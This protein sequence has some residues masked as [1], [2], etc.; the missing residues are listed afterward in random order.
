MCIK[1]SLNDVFPIR[2]LQASD[3]PR[4][5]FQHDSPGWGGLVWD[6]NPSKH[7]GQ[8]SLFAILIA[9]N[10]I[11][12]EG[13]PLFFLASEI[14]LG[15]RDSFLLALSLLFLGDLFLLA[16]LCLTIV[17]PSWGTASPCSKLVSTGVKGSMLGSTTWVVANSAFR[18]LIGVLAV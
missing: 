4:Y 2:G 16:F 7:L 13:L 14:C 11:E 5:N 17:N 15:P 6:L 8:S 10:A 18:A 3:V 9:S 1:K 12:E